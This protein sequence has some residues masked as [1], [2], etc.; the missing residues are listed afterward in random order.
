MAHSS[1]SP[2][3]RYLRIKRSDAVCGADIPGTIAS[4]SQYRFQG[5]Y[6]FG[7]LER[8]MGARGT[9]T[10]RTRHHVDGWPDRRSSETNNQRVRGHTCQ[11]RLVPPRHPCESI[12]RTSVSNCS[13]CVNRNATPA[14]SI[15]RSLCT[16]KVL[17]YGRSWQRP[18]TRSHVDPRYRNYAIFQ[19][20]LAVTVTHISKG[21]RCS[22]D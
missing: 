16:S 3:S 5:S 1:P 20:R 8:R 15:P 9:P 10:C 18:R 22:G 21:L 19:R 13:G 11:F 4:N 6:E 17:T 14:R 12:R 2:S 7:P